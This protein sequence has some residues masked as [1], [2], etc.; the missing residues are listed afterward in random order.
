MPTLQQLIEQKTALE[1]QI[2]ELRQA[3]RAD[4]IARAK[5]IIADHDLA[6]A[7]VFGDTRRGRKPDVKDGRSVKVAVKYRDGKGNEWTGRGR[8]PE[9]IKGKDRAQFAV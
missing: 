5:K 7:D 6:P 3:E 9:W 1:A 4:A 2:A 8:E